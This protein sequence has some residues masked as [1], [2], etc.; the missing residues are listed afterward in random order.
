MIIQLLK[1]TSPRC[2][3]HK[4]SAKMSKVSEVQPLGVFLL[5]PASNHGEK[6]ITIPKTNKELTGLKMGQR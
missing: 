5:D 1:L 2:P 6:Y 4:Y 3:T